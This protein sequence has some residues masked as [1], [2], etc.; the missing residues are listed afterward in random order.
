M[1]AARLSGCLPQLFIRPI[2]SPARLSQKTF[3][4]IKILLCCMQIGLGL[5]L[6]AK[7][8]QEPPWSAGW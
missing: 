7:I 2:S 6:L 5:N 4:P 1:F 3:S 8:T